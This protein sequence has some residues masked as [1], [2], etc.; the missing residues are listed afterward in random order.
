MLDIE[1]DD[2]AGPYYSGVGGPFT[3]QDICNALNQTYRASHAFWD[4]LWGTEH[5]RGSSIPDFSKWKNAAPVINACTLVNTEYPQK[6][7][8]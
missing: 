3:P 2:I 1:A 5:V 6:Y 8:Q 7:P 4:V